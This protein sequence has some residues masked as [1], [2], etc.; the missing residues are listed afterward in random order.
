MTH[1][2][3]II[4]PYF[5]FN[6]EH[7]RAMGIIVTSMPAV[8]RPK[9]RTETI[10]IP[11]RNGVLHVD[12]GSYENYTKTAECAIIKRANI[13]A[14][15]AWLT[16]S[17]TAI[18]ST[19]PDKYYRVRIDNAISIEQMMKVFQKFQVHFDTHPFKYSVNETDD[20][21]I[22][23]QPSLLY[24]R[25]TV[26]AEPTI[27]VV[28]SGTVTLSINGKG[29]R[30]SAVDGHVTIHSEVMEVE[31]DGENKNGTYLPL[32]EEDW[33]F[34]RFEVGENRINWTGNVE[35]IE[36]TPNWRWL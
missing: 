12:D 11:G 22:L 23:Q 19:E 26:E 5:I 13:D 21:V 35:R 16:G 3:Q 31:T 1:G 33:L 29:Y 34:P 4:N 2:E 17:G 36:I 15:C 9:R 8:C 10:D 18:F 14:I 24:N 32:Q 20:Q 27:T 6:G 28:G 7:S 25:G 30:L